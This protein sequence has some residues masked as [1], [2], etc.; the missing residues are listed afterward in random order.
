METSEDC[1]GMHCIRRLR[2]PL[3]MTGFRLKKSIA[4]SNTDDSSHSNISLAC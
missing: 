3:K 1:I 2:Y 4:I